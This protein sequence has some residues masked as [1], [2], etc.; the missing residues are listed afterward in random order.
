MLTEPEPA[1]AGS[2]FGIRK[3][4]YVLLSLSRKATSKPDVDQKLFRIIEIDFH[5]M[6]ML[7]P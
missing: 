5:Q 4:S 6:L 1:A 7:L 3:A 2:V